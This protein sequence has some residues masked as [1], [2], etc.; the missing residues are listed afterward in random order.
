MAHVK[1]QVVL[2]VSFL[3]IVNEIWHNSAITSPSNS[4]ELYFGLMSLSGDDQSSGTLAGI[5][6]ALDEINSRD[7]LLPAGYLLN[8]TFT[9]SKVTLQTNEAIISFRMF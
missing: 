9:D 2:I 3:W 4:T 8:Y 7:D 1:S 5:Q 6:A